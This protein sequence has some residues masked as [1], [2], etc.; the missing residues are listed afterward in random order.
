[1]ED[2]YKNSNIE[3]N[4]NYWRFGKRYYE[5]KNNYS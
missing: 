1:M 4:V 5:K 3:L 2:Q